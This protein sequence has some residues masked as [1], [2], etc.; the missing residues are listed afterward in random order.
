MAF[1]GV[2][3]MSAVAEKL[4]TVRI[5]AAVP[6]DTRAWDEY[7]RSHPHGSP[8]HLDA[9]RRVIL[10]AFGHPVDRWIARDGAGTVCGVLPI[11]Y[12]RSRLFGHYGVSMPFGNYGG[13]L[14]DDEAVTEALMDA[15]AGRARELGLDHL[16]FRDAERRA[17]HWPVRDSKLIMRRS[18]PTATDT[19]WSEL[20]SKL[21]AQV[22]R[23]MRED[24]TTETGGDEL[25]DDFYQVFAR[26]MRDLG[27]PVYGRGFF[28]AVLALC[29]CASIVV[30]RH[31]GRPVAAAFLLGFHGRLEIPWASSLRSANPL[32]VNML[33]YW[34]CLEFAVEQGYTEFDF[35]RSSIDSGTHR[36]KRQ[37]GAAEHPCYWHY[38]LPE[39]TDIPALNPDNPKYRLAI[40][41]WQH[42]P[43]AVA[44]RLGPSIVRNLP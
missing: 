18:L 35:G 14:A 41:L 30:V 27:T 26:N 12:L 42:L 3:G 10:T 32:G 19:L 15:A 7:V 43:L 25:L 37:W 4:G 40:R 2:P 31:A 8:Y 13:A 36:F 34:R 44:N 21:R 28:R 11:V 17:E 1:A 9:W 20:G 6:A 38:W 39:G 23:P 22:R 29:E 16:E 5:D 24:V 33:L